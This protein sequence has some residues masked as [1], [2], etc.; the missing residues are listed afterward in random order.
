MTMKAILGPK[1]VNMEDVG[2]LSYVIDMVDNK[3]GRDVLDTSLKAVGFENFDRFG[4][5]VMINSTLYKFADR[6]KNEPIKA[7]AELEAN[8]SDIDTADVI[9]RLEKVH[10]LLYN[11]PKRN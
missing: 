5:E 8:V 4:K 7:K 3:L 2:I 1:Y 10:E 6:A 11:P 9:K